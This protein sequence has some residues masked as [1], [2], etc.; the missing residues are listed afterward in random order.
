MS[1]TRR[2]ALAATLA[3]LAGCQAPIARSRLSGNRDRHAI[4][5]SARI[6]FVGDVMLARRVERRHE[7][8]AR[9]SVWGTM[10][11]HL[12]ELDGFVANLECVL[13]DRG[14]KWP[15]KSW[16]FRA[17]PDWA[18]PA[19]EAADPTAV[20]LANNHT[21]DYGAVSL[22][23]TMGHLD[24]IDVSHA[25]AGTNW[26][27]AI[28]PVIVDVEDVTVALIGLTDRFRPFAARSNAPGTAY[29][30]LAVDSRTTR[31][32][33]FDALSRA[34]EADPDLVVVSL[35]WGPNYAPKTDA[36]RTFGRWLVDQ[37]VDVVHG[38]SAHV[39]RGVEVYRGRPILYDTGDFVNDY[40]PREG[41]YNDRSFLFELLVDDGLET[42]RLV[43]SEIRDETVHLADEVARSWLHDE[44]RSLSGE[45]ETAIEDVGDGTLSIP[46]SEQ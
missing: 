17:D 9:E 40:S 16:H 27:A 5:G 21:L 32:T 3:P 8:R 46:L 10:H 33:V 45:F 28:E 29:L 35:H 2:E 18:V 14:E 11:D 4:T 34:D 19:L 39:I 43:P 25:G 30:D 6:G 41:Y 20:S 1:I 42:L 23:D 26:N 37:G 12:R 13:T 44:M 38:H 31:S 15:E 22:M 36:H 7:H 24:S